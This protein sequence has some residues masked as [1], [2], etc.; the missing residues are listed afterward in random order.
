M[1][2]N[3]KYLQYTYRQDIV[4]QYFKHR[5]AYDGESQILPKDQT[6]KI[7]EETKVLATVLPHH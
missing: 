3:V 2:K 4:I 6:W 7:R 5:L 1:G